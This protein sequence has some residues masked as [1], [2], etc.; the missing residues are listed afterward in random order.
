V[1]QVIRDYGLAHLNA[2]R[3][4]TFRR[5]LTRM[6]K[7]KKQSQKPHRVKNET[8]KGAPPDLKA[9]PTRQ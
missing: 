7:T 3:E 2:Y 9:Y 5:A 1:L 8:P 4:R 6:T